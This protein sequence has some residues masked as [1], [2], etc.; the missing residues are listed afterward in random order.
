[1]A[2]YYELLVVSQLNTFYLFIESNTTILNI[3][4]FK[5]LNE[6][7]KRKGW[8]EGI[9]RACMRICWNTVRGAL[10]MPSVEC[11]NGFE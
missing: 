11:I 5:Y 4:R 3:K 7:K 1:M 6:D 2:G 10:D 9:Y 8:F